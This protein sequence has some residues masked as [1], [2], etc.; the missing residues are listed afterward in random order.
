MTVNTAVPAAPAAA[1]TPAAAPAPATPAPASMPAPAPQ[2]TGGFL[3]HIKVPESSPADSK[4]TPPATPPAAAAAPG[5]TPDPAQPKAGEQPPVVFKSTVRGREYTGEELTKAFESSSAEGIR[6]NQIVKQA[7]QELAA[8]RVAR[9]ELEDK[10]NET[11][12]FKLLTKSEMKELDTVDLAEYISKRDKWETQ[13]ETRKEALTKAQAAHK[14]ETEAVKEHIYA[15]SEHM[16]TNAADFPGYKDLM[17]VMEQIL[18]RAPHMAGRRET[19]DLL[20]F[21]AL[22]LQ[23]YREGRA[24]KDAEQ[25]AKDEVAAQA[26]AQAAAAGGGNPPAPVGAPT[27]IEDDSD[28]AFNKRILAKSPKSIF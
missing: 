13:K 24:S 5:I 2:S 28:E 22:G 19:P 20:Y 23:K 17:P 1:A 4:Q 18:D 25:K 6:L 10:A 14:A 16:M 11:P 27:P 9:A 3:D 8:E 7:Q 12:P 15:R 26:A 21:A